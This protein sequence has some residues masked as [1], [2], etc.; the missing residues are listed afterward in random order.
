MS[1]TDKLVQKLLQFPK[2]MRFS[3]VEFV[4]ESRGYTLA[5]TKGSHNIFKK[6]GSP[7]IEVPTINGRDVK[8]EY[9]KDVAAMLGLKEE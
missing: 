5:R 4:L 8:V 9:L 2:T 3:E 6:P 1:R 7:R